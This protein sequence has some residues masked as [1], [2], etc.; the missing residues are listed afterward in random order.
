ME[1]R[2][3]INWQQQTKQKKTRTGLGSGDG[4]ADDVDVLDL[5][6]GHVHVAVRA[7]QRDRLLADLLSISLSIV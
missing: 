6:D 1:R 2:F 5:V 3:G 4:S 7:Q